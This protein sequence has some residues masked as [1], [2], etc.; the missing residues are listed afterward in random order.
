MNVNVIH[1]INPIH[2]SIHRSN[3]FPNLSASDPC[4]SA[5]AEPGISGAPQQWRWPGPRGRPAGAA[6]RTQRGHGGQGH[7]HAAALA[8]GWW[9]GVGVGDGQPVEESVEETLW[10]WSFFFCVFSVHC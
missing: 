5:G 7:G 2:L 1:L 6:Q 10:I 3:L 9:L 8:G 4:C